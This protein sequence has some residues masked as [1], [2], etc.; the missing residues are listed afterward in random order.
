MIMT[1]EQAKHLAEVLNAY[2][3][4]KPIEVSLDG[5]WGEVDL[6]EYSFDENESYRI[7]KEPKYRPFKNAKE[8]FEEIQK[9]QPIGWLYWNNVFVH[10]PEIGVGYVEFDSCVYSFVEAFNNGFT[11]V[12][13]QPFG[14]KEY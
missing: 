2:A 13:G 10:I 9:H 3:D 7:K 5:E 12:D 14:I 6:N 11:F 8:C 1:K 4:G